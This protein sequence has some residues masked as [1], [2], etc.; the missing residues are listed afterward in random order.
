LPKKIF[1]KF[2]VYALLVTAS[3][4]TSAD[5]REYFTINRFH[6]DIDVHE[7]GSIVV[8]E[9]IRLTFHQERHGIY[10]EIPYKYENELGDAVRMPVKV[11]GVTRGDGS[12]WNYRVSKRGNVVNIRIGHPEVYVSGVQMYVITYRVK[13]ALLFFDDHDELYWNVTGNYWDVPIEEASATTNLN[14]ETPSGQL[15]ARCYTGAYGRRESDCDWETSGNSASFATFRPLKA[16]EGLTVVFGWDKGIVR[17]PSAW[18][19]FAAR[20][21]LVE[22]WVFI[23]PV[24]VLVFMIVQ[25]RRK[26]RDPRVREAVT[27]MYEPPQFDGKDLSA[28]EVGSLIDEKMDPRDLTATVVG[29]AVKGYVK[30]EE[31]VKE[32]IIPMFDTAD[33]KLHK[34]KHPD[35]E[36]SSFETQLMSQLFSGSA[37]VITVSKL[38]NKFY[39]NLKSLRG[40]LWSDLKAKKYFN[41]SPATVRATYVAVGIAFFVTGGLIAKFSMGGFTIRGVIVAALCGGIVLAFSNAMPVKTRAG[42]RA[43]FHVLGFQEFMNRADRDRLERMGKDVFY[44]YMPY[45]IALGVVD[46]WAEAFEGIYGEPPD[47]YVSPGGFRSFSP[48]TFSRS[49]GQ[50]ASSLSSATFSAPRGSGTGGGGGF[51][52]GGGGG[53]GGGS[54]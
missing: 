42:A 37:E 38:K 40:T 16:R 9:A 39:K 50:A 54:W 52:G 46:H 51:S 45:A 4:S 31:I 1:T 19:R 30:I 8:R 14:S 20:Y 49:I 21:N 35:S 25:W 2:A 3:L 7:D 53:G 22:N 23:I 36:L 28:A 10:R 12:E 33:Y 44:R 29:L 11:L 5:A 43:H 34:L 32:G 15:L 47:W 27:V 24:I 26:G 18:Q 48:V 17:P 13:N 6:A 41:I